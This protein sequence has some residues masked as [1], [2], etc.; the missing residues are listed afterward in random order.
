MVHLVHVVY[1]VDLGG[2]LFGDSVEVVVIGDS[3]EVVVIGDS[4][5]L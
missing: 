4:L 2:R 3:V 5:D 1:L